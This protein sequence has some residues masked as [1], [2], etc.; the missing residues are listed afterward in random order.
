MR[1]IILTTYMLLISVT[2]SGPV[3]AERTAPDLLNCDGP[4]VSY[5]P[6][7]KLVS[8]QAPD[9]PID[10]IRNKTVGWVFLSYSVLPDGRTENVVVTDSFPSG[11]FD[12]NAVRSIQSFVYE[13][14][15]VEGDKFKIQN[16]LHFSL[17]DKPKLRRAVSKK[18]KEAQKLILEGRN[19]DQA[20]RV[21]DKISLRKALNLYEIMVIQQAYGLLAYKREDSVRAAFYLDRAQRIERGMDSDLSD[22]ATQTL[23]NAF[24]ETEQFCKA[25]NTFENWKLPQDSIYRKTLGP[26][27]GY[28]RSALMSGGP[29]ELD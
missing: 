10:A 5:L 28:I 29:I 3:K 8:G 2:Q 1:I 22:L 12:A 6:S 18:L 24:V 9:Y 4:D 23:V 17:D 26:K 16:A 15:F 27:I 13:D 14:R 11:L 20:E 19:L 21:L 7:L 25:V